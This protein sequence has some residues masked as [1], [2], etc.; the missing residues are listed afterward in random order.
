MDIREKIKRGYYLVKAEYPKHGIL[1][2]ECL[3]KIDK[4]NKFCPDCGN[5]I[6]SVVSEYNDAHAERLKKYFTEKR[7][8]ESKFKR[9]AL[10]Y[11]GI[12]GHPNADKA[13][14]FAWDKGHSSG[15]YNVLD[16]LEGIAEVIL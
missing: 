4:K 2:C 15:H 6:G 5:E 1:I 13:F 16:W 14:S 12:D 9:D 10:G 3:A 8:A 11:V 7:E